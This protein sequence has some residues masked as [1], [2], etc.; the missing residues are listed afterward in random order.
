MIVPLVKDKHQPINH[1]YETNSD[2]ISFSKPTFYRYVNDD[3]LSLSNIDLPKKVTYK[4]RKR[5]KENN[6]KQ[7]YI[8]NRNFEDFLNYIEK[9]TDAS[10]VEMDTVEGTKGG[11]CFLTLFIRKTSLL[12]IFFN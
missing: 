8:K 3:V 10:I 11:K 9:H 12:L 1:I 2:I 4:P 6:N 7:N 5:K